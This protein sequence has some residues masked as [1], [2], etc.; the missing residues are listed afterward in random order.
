MKWIDKLRATKEDRRNKSGCDMW[1]GGRDKHRQKQKQN[2]TIE[3]S[4][5]QRKQP[6]NRKCIFSP[7]I[8]P[9][10]TMCAV[11]VGA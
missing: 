1:G 6:K 4:L 11:C 10:A 7:G 5:S 2:K 8:N 3:S 9:V